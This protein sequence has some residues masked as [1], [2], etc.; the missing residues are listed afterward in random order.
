MT[1][2]RARP[3]IGFLARGVARHFEGEGLIKVLPL[4]LPIDLPPVGII[5]MRGRLR[6]PSSEQLIDC[7]RK[8]AKH[9]AGAK[10]A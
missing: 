10:D 7:L 9:G 2:I 5:T 8:A 3:A 4:R 1:F 6:T